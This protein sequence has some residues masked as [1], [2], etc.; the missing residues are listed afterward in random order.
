MGRIDEDEAPSVIQY[1]NL[2]LPEF[3]IAEADV[4]T[5]GV[6][7]WA[8]KNPN[9]SEKD[10]G[11]VLVLA[12]YKTPKQLVKGGNR[13]LEVYLAGEGKLMIEREGAILEIPC[14]SRKT[15]EFDLKIGDIMQ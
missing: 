9:D 5:E 4:V 13:T 8:Y 12:G 3:N 6:F 1:L 14:Y 10:L 2:S 15:L 7:C 11:V